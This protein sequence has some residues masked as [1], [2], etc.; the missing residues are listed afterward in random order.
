[1]EIVL[2]AVLLL[3]GVAVVLRPLLARDAGAPDPTTTPAG[4]DGA[5]DRALAADVARYRAALRAGTVCARC[6]EANP[7]DSHFCADCGRQL[8]GAR[9]ARAATTP[10]P[11]A[12]KDAP[13]DSGAANAGAGSH[14]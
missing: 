4:D 8:G 1:M 10:T 6:K 13:A 9:K 5:D 3:A 11:A 14:A 12:S 2:I 7:P